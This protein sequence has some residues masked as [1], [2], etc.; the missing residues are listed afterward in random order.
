MAALRSN[1]D[2]LSTDL[3][4]WLQWNDAPTLGVELIDSM[5]QLLALEEPW[6]AIYDRDPESGFFLSWDW[7]AA[8]FQQY[9]P[10][11]RVL[12]VRN[13][14]GEYLG[15]FPISTRLRWSRSEQQFQTILE[16][17]GRAG[18]SELTGIVCNR[19]HEK[20]VVSVLAGRGNSKMPT[21]SSST[22]SA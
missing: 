8:L 17:G 14:E 21:L 22:F 19:L 9:A 12:A 1:I 20:A 15:F 11:V 13:T 16:P 5:E 4:D 2:P 18:L 7:I 6:R 3:P 10:R